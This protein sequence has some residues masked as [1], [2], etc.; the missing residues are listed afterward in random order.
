MPDPRDVNHIL[1]VI[2]NEK[3]SM[4]PA[5]P[6]MYAAINNHPKV[7]KYDLHSVKACVSGG[8]SLPVEVATQFEKITG[9]RLVEGYG[10]SEC[11]PLACGNPVHGE[12]RV[13][14]IGVPVPNTRAVIVSLEPDDDGNYKELPPGEEGELVIY[15][16]QVMA[17]Y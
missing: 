16:P 17:G 1:R 3:I 6:A 14:S 4:Y 12:R 7:S 9:G 5:V 13:G 15:G 11:S 8:S 10:L 2:H